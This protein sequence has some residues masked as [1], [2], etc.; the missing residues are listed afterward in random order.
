M[1]SG[2]LFFFEMCGQL[3][4]RLS[5]DR[6]N[7]RL[8]RYTLGRAPREPLSTDVM[9]DVAISQEGS[10]TF[11]WAKACLLRYHDVV[12]GGGRG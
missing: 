8:P 10:D 3:F 2:T 7:S 9:H 6:K 12:F 11:D 5:P 1:Q 4:F